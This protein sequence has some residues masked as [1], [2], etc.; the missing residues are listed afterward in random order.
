MHLVTLSARRKDEAVDVLFD[1]FRDYPVMRHIVGAPG[2]T[3][4]RRARQL[5]DFFTTARFLGE[6][7]VMAVA[8][9]GGALVAIANITR[10]GERPTPAALGPLRE[11]LWRDLGPE[12]RA[13]YEALVQIWQ[14]F[15]IARP[16]YH[17]NML[18]VRRTHQKRGAARLL[19][20]AVHALS[21]RS[22]ESTGVSLTTGDPVNVAFYER[23]GYRIVAEA[24]VGGAFTTWGFFRAEPGR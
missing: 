3:Y 20:D 10:P 7:P 19:L 17:L 8:D 5:I 21:A 18:G 12:A 2:E 13:R 9:D 1:A 15:G 16:Q 14:G 22:T 24:A 6:D 23:F 4:A 11:A